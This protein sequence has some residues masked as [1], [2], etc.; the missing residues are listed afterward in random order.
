MT[1]EGLSPEN[2]EIMEAIKVLHFVPS[3]KSVCPGLEGFPAVQPEN[4]CA[5]HALACVICLPDFTPDNPEGSLVCLVNK[6]NFRVG[7]SFYTSTR[8]ALIFV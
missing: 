1:W 3:G 4:P 7:L 8:L 6:F 2:L 5:R